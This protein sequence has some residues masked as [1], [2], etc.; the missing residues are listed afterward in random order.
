MAK[1]KTRGLN[2]GTTTPV[3]GQH[4]KRGPRGGHTG[5]E[6]TSVE[7]KPLP[8]AGRGE[9]YDLVDRTRHRRG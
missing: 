4:E 9:T 2:P 1:P 3:S 5:Q 6:V 8:P 7:G